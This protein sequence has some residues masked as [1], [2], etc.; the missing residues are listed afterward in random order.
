VP[1]H[2]ARIS[3][4]CSTASEAA[5]FA[6]RHTQNMQGSW[7]MPNALANQQWG[8]DNP[9]TQHPLESPLYGAQPWEDVVEILVPLPVH[10]H[11]G[12]CG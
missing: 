1:P 12:G 9:D 3:A 6:F 8:K 11:P 2:V 5:S 10:G 4:G 7:S